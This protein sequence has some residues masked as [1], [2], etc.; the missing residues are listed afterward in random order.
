MKWSGS[1]P[2][3]HTSIYRTG[4][5]QLYNYYTTCVILVFAGRVYTVCIPRAVYHSH[6]RYCTVMSVKHS[7]PPPVLLYTCI[8]LS[9]CGLHVH[10]YTYIIY[11]SLSRG[12]G[13]EGYIPVH[14][15][16]CMAIARRAIYCKY[17]AGRVGDCAFSHLSFEVNRILRHTHTPSVS[18]SRSLSLSLSV[19]IL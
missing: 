7:L 9:V 10:V 3:R 19:A 13:R 2:Y 15:M 16:G 14:V 4:D 8:C 18:L 5:G 1:R 11:I 17:W 6:E 12:A